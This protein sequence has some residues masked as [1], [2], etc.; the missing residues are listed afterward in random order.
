MLPRQVTKPT[1]KKKSPLATV[2]INNPAS[3]PTVTQKSP[4][5][6]EAINRP[7]RKPA[8]TKQSPAATEATRPIRQT[9][10]ATA[11][12]ATP[13]KIRAVPKKQPKTHCFAPNNRTL[14]GKSATPE[15]TFTA[16]KVKSATDYFKVFFNDEIVDL[17][18]T[19]SN[20][21]AVQNN[22]EF[23][24]TKLDLIKFMA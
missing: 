11:A 12:T 1:V 20:L 19:H 9:R 17:I 15:I 5:A 2:A 18:V 16:E 3:K 7:A 22:S 14:S 10:S 23:R 21:Y 4:S 13:A 24:M 8:L 6:T